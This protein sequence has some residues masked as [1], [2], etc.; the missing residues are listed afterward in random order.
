MEMGNENIRMCKILKG[1]IF[2]MWS[3]NIAGL[4]KIPFIVSELCSGQGPHLE[5]A[6]SSTCCH[7]NGKK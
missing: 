2:H 7:G 1:D 6:L 5:N 4:V 3:D